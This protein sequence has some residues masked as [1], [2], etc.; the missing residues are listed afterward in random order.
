MQR[1]IV[2]VGSK[3]T[4]IDICYGKESNHILS[5]PIEFEE[6]YKKEN[7]LVKEDIDKLIERV[8]ILNVVYD[9]IHIFGTGIFRN[10]N[11][12]DRKEFIEEFKER[13]GREFKIL[14][15]DEEKKLHEKG[16]IYLVNRNNWKYFYSK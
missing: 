5:L 2:E 6:D 11:E 13:T 14:D 7:K 3:N 10:L 16:A 12:E 4:N 9:D 1:I 8:N 15:N